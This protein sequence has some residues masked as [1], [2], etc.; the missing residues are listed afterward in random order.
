MSRGILWCGFAVVLA[1]GGAAV[2]DDNP[3]AKRPA[4]PKAKPK[5][6]PVYTD[7][8][9]ADDDYAFQGEYRGWQTPSG[10]IRSAEAIGLQ[11]IAE[12]QGK[13]Q[14]VKYYG[15]LPGAGWKG[16]EKYMLTGERVG[17]RVE[18]LGEQADIV[19]ADGV[20][21]ILDHKGKRIGE[22]QRVERTSPTMGAAPPP[23]AIVLFNGGPTEHFINP[24]LS[25][26]GYLLAG[27]DTKG[28]WNDF[29]LHG[30]FRLP[31]KP[32]ARG[33]DRGNSG[34]YLQGRYEVQVLDSFGLEG[35][36]NECGALY[37]TRRPNL[38]MCLPPLQWQTYDLE[39]HAPKFDADGKKVQDMRIT[40]WHNGVPIHMNQPIP[41]KTGAGKPE[42]PEPL[43]IKLQDHGNPVVYR[44]LWLVDLS[45]PTSGSANLPLPPSGPP[46]PITFYPPYPYPAPPPVQVTAGWIAI[47]PFAP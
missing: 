6:N 33:Q 47:A 3:A 41:N 36:E 38:N 23:G 39:F 21:T 19:V 30:E 2:A 45:Q 31:Y 43:P 18:L 17:N 1:A 5:E 14:A 26:D 27:T 25:P 32:E 16:R 44:N 10:T 13:F 20:A 24:K 8:A 46:V 9:Q 42:A 7:P 40:I 4:A 22:L 28:A 37:K 35:I 15:G 29:R 12:G 11:V 34:F